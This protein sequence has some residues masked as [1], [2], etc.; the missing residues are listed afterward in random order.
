[1]GVV[2]KASKGVWC[3]LS[4]MIVKKVKVCSSQRFCCIGGCQAPGPTIRRGW[5]GRLTES[6]R[7]L[8]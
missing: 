5:D 4:C 2:V 6:S 1:M 7:G 8:M 3:K